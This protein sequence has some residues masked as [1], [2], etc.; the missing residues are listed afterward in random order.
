MAVERMKTS[1]NIRAL[2]HELGVTRGVLY[3]WRDRLEPLERRRWRWIFSKVPCKKSRL[4][5]SAAA[6]LA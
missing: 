4:D 3:K 5:A 6:A 1:E 2:A